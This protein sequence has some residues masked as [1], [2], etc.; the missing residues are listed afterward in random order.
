LR[1][2]DNPNQIPLGVR[3]K[4]VDPRL[5]RSLPR[6]SPTMMRKRDGWERERE[7]EREREINSE[8]EKEREREKE[9]QRR[10]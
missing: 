10:I 5:V 3:G 6:R 2:I 7:R 1:F 8:N 4:S 9:N